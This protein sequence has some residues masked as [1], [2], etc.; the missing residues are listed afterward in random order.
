MGN[1]R[2]ERGQPCPECRKGV[3]HTCGQERKDAVL[4]PHMGV[5]LCSDCLGKAL[6]GGSS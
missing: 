3:C 5:I 6:F 1:D 4:A 2:S